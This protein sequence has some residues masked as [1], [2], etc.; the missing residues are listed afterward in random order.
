MGTHSF[1]SLVVEVNFNTCS[2]DKIARF[3]TENSILLINELVTSVLK[4]SD[5]KIAVS[6]YHN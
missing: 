4:L 1:T 6:T 5:N 3:D 2:V